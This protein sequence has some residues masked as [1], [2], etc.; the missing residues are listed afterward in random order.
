MS[1]KL[2][3]QSVDALRFLAADMIEKANSGHPGVAID[4][5]PMAYQLWEKNMNFNPEDPKWIN[6]D[7]FV[8]SSGHGSS[9]LY[10]LLHFN[11]FGVSMDDI[12]QFR[13]WG[14]LTPGHPEYGH[15]PGV[16]ATT[17]P[18]G[19]GISMAV[20]M[21]LAEKHLAAIYNKPGYDVIDHYTYTILGDGDL[22]EGVSEEALNIAGDKGLGKLIALYDSNDVTLDGPLSLS[23]S[24]KVK[25]RVEAAGWDYQLVEQG[26]TDLD[27]IQAAI[28][29]AKHTSKPSL[30]EVKTTIGYGSPQAGT[31]AVHGNPLGEE[32]LKAMREKLGWDYKPFEFPKEI[33][34][35]FDKCVAA[36]KPAYDAWQKMFADYSK[37]YPEDAKHMTSVKLDTDGLKSNYKPGDEVSTR[38][39]G[40]DV[41]QQLAAKNPQLWGGAADLYSSNKTYL[42]DDGNFTADNPKGRNVYFG[43]R[44]F[45]MATSINGINLHGG[46][47]FFGSAFFVFSDYLRGAVRIAALM[48]LPSIF[49]FSHD[50]IAVGEDGP[51]HEPIEQLASFRAMPGLNVIRPAD[52][53][54]MVSAWKFI[55]NE[56]DAPTMLVASRQNLPVL[57][58]TENA[59]VEKG[60]YILAD[61]DKDTPDGILIAAGSEV[62]LA[63]NAKKEL[64]KQGVDVRVVSMPSTDLFNQQPADYREK[65][66]PKAVTKRMA[67]EMAASQTWYQ[68]TGL[69]GAVFGIDK[70]GA[71]APGAEVIKNYGFTTENVVKSFKDL[72][73]K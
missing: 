69:D 57:K 8:L 19:Q 25:S 33:T 22:N 58:E 59:P 34:D 14:S 13:Q 17:G 21:A 44:E 45:G 65:V 35:N 10:A 40:H 55:G 48:K 38:V 11:G 5:A 50:S 62:S 6:R 72:L 43:I 7:R 15:T 32:N 9:Q 70:F 64:A 3:H 73:N 67:I 54:E 56:T 46:S 4:I 16:D 18:L 36:K 20:G 30:I 71:S 2:D 12:K 1:T 49:I 23:T 26:N 29:H 61:S 39:A 51:T 68:Y 60:G 63:M 24:E 37:K 41:L 53:N 66:L 42:D 28:E 52:A 27:D 47:R 31:N